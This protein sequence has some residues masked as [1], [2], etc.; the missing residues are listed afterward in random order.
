MEIEENDFKV[1]FKKYLAKFTDIFQDDFNRTEAEIVKKEVDA[2]DK[3]KIIDTWVEFLKYEC[4]IEQISE[5]KYEI[6]DVGSFIAEDNTSSDKYIH[7]IEFDENES[8]SSIFMRFYFVFCCLVNNVKSSD[9][10][11]SKKSETTK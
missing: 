11:I 5:T 6:Y 10:S 7:I 4:P 3:K 8:S 2:L 1:I 9:Y